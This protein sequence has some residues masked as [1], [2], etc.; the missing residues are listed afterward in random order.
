[1]ERFASE[2]LGYKLKVDCCLEKAIAALKRTHTGAD[3]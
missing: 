3:E 1:V 2:Q